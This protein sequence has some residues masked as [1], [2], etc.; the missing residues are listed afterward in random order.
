MTGRNQF[1]HPDDPAPEEMRDPDDPAPEEMRD[2]DDPAPEEMR[3]PDDPAPEEMRDPDDPAPEEMRDPDDPAAWSQQNSPERMLAREDCRGRRH[4]AR[5]RRKRR[6]FPYQYSGKI[7][8]RLKEYLV[9]EGDTVETLNDLAELRGMAGL[10]RVLERYELTAHRL[11]DLKEGGV[12]DPLRGCKCKGPCK[13]KRCPTVHELERDAAS[14]ALPPLHSLASYWRI[15]V[16]DQPRQTCPEPGEMRLNGWQPSHRR[17]VLEILSHLDE[18]TEV[19]LAYRELAVTD[20][21]PPDG[22]TYAAV[23]EYLDSEPVGINARWAWAQMSGNEEGVGFVDLEQGWIPHEDLDVALPPI[24]GDNRHKEGLYRG[25]HGSAV[26]G[27]VIG[28]VNDRGVAGIARA[29]RSARVVSHYNKDE[30]KSLNVANAIRQAIP[31][32][33]VGDVLLLEVQRS[34]LPTEV[35]EADRDAIRLAVSH[36]IIVIEAAGNGNADLDRYIDQRGE[37]VLDRRDAGYCESGAIMVGAAFASRP[38]DRCWGRVGVGSNSGSRIDCFAHGS[39][40]VTTGYGDLNAYLDGTGDEEADAERA[41]TYRFG[42]TS[43]ASPIIAGTALLV[44]AIHLDRTGAQLSPWDMRNLL[45]DPANGTRQGRRVKGR[46]GV[47]PDLRRILRSGLGLVSD[48]HLRDRCGETNTLPAQSRISA[49][50]DIAVVDKGSR[51]PSITDGHAGIG[52]CTPGREYEVC[53][54]MRNRGSDPVK[55]RVKVYWSEVATLITPSMWNLLD[56]AD[57]TLETVAAKVPIGDRP[58]WSQ[59][60]RWQP[61]ATTAGGESPAHFCLT[62][63]IEEPLK[64]KPELPDPVLPPGFAPHFDWKDYRAF[65]RLHN[66]AC[67]NLHLVDSKHDLNED[68]VYELAF[69]VTGTPDLARTFD[70]EIIRQLPRG[71]RVELDAPLALASRLARRR[72]W[73]CVP[74]GQ[75][76]ARLLL[77]S[78]PRLEISRLRLLAGAR[79]ECRF[80]VSGKDLE[81]GDALAIRQLYRDEEVGRIT[82]RLSSESPRASD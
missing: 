61:P 66:V 78:L 11:V 16:S 2:P 57:S 41:Y 27:Q 36:G 29:V 54:R 35:D 8:V 28:K 77:P 7:I 6:P 40:V 76:E 13:C 51:A 33:A 46:I 25:C 47:M 38:H 34:F 26:L 65:L 56:P 21:V 60:V 4:V 53:V 37:R 15:D 71:T 39:C 74:E 3:D 50:P 68:G 49:S 81:V 42:G 69:A 32:M 58:V 43:A 73:K 70:F 62:A 82:W 44:Q 30:R 80:R 18:L 52:K 55:G 72:L 1:T 24:F 19:D 10:Q 17:T 9:S 59:P 14:S 75:D 79:F 63:V 67:R 5:R 23:Q 48:L 45:S 12:R 22:D 20:P 31:K 64:P